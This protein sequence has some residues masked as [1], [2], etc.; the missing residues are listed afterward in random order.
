MRYPEKQRMETRRSMHEQTPLEIAA[1]A[2]VLPVD[3]DA[4]PQWLKDL[5]RWVD[6][7][8]EEINGQL[9]KPPFNPNTGAR[10]D[11][12]DAATWADFEEAKCAYLDGG[13]AGV[14]IVLTGGLVAFDIDDCIHE[15]V[16]HPKVVRFIKF[17]GTYF[18][19]SP[20]RKGVRGF[21][22]GSVPDTFK[23]RGK[24]EVYEQK[25]Y[26]S[27]T[28][29][30]IS[31]SA[32]QII[33][34]QAKLNRVYHDI[35]SQREAAITARKRRAEPVTAIPSR[36]PFTIDESIQFALTKAANRELF[37]RLFY[38]DPSL[39]GP[40]GRYPSKSE[41]DFAL[42]GLIIFWIGTD[43]QKIDEVFRQSSLC[44]DKWDEPRGVDRYGKP[45]TYGSKT[46]NE[47]LIGAKVRKG[48]RPH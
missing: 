12:N 41:A 35:F 3:F 25:Q 42:V 31:F 18:E 23:R 24:V 21:L 38:A 43:K 9:K 29:H 27:V 14:G 16:I 6:W 47:A 34:D 2:E 7:I 28:G 19:V 1:M 22:V 17:L 13:Y 45:Q 36:Q 11:V 10:A 30:H 46:I 15:G 20:G 5:H 40:N 26:V 32:P 33:A 39:W 8:Y 44:D 48:L 37:S 4:I